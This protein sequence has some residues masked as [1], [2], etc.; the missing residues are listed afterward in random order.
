MLILTRKHG[1]AILI[2]DSIVVRVLEI[3]GDSVRIGV[4]APRDIA[5][6]RPEAKNRTP[7]D[8]EGNR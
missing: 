5:V 1:Q 3:A 8:V 2:G 4:D 7:R 6:L